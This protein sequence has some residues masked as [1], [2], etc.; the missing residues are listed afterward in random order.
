MTTDK[1]LERIYKGIANRRRIAIIR[2][3]KAGRATVS[4]IAAAI[5]LSHKSTSRHLQVLSA[6]GFVSSEQ[7]GLFVYYSLD[8]QSERIAR[9]VRTF[10]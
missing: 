8:T 5:K 1:E 9:V 10:F 3:L 2:I 6:A 4:D 7:T